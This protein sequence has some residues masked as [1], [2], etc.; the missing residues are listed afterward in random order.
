VPGTSRGQRSALATGNGLPVPQCLG[1]S[2]RYRIWRLDGVAESAKNPGG[3]FRG[4]TGDD[5]SLTK[6]PPF[7][8]RIDMS[9]P[10]CLCVE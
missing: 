1:L 3:H 5:R 8:A 4:I 2:G 6:P 7:P 9:A 10:S